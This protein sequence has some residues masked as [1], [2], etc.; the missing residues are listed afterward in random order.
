MQEMTGK[1]VRCVR[2]WKRVGLRKG[3]EYTVAAKIESLYLS[4]DT[5]GLPE[6]RHSEGGPRGASE[7]RI[8]KS[9]GVVSFKK[10]QFILVELGYPYF[11]DA[12]RFEPMQPTP[13][14]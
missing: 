3:H 7:V 9:G 5:V 6:G 2:G 13:I 14:G 10:P 4:A 12:E 1:K 8:P 11:V